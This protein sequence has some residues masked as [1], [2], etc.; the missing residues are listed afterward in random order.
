MPND[1]SPSTL[2]KIAGAMAALGAAW[3]A[4]RAVTVAWRLTTGHRPPSADDDLDGQ[5]VEIAAAA[6]LTGAAVAVA[7]LLAARQTTRLAARV[8]ANRPAHR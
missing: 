8:N 5:F 4:Q 7:R 2:A 6:A 1:S 3:A